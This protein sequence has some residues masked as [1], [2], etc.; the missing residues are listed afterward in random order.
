MVQT[1]LLTCTTRRVR[2]NR[3]A[4]TT[5]YFSFLRVSCKT[6]SATLFWRKL[7]LSTRR[8]GTGKISN[9]FRH[10]NKTENS[11]NKYQNDYFVLDESC[12]MQKHNSSHILSRTSGFV[13]TLL[14]PH[15]EMLSDFSGHEAVI[16]STNSGICFSKKISMIFALCYN[17]NAL[18]K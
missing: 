5:R 14:A 12:M 17:W 4:A 7:H 11:Q 13:L 16:T 3:T 8:N 1:Y 6:F 10:E 2:T 18:E 15:S 9:W